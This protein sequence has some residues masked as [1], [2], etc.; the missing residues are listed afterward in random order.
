MQII[1]QLTNTNG[2]PTIYLPLFVIVFISMVKDLFEDL[3]RH[4]SDKEENMKEVLLLENETFVR[5]EWQEL[6]CGN[7]I[8]VF[9][10]FKDY[11]IIF[12]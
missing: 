9:I 1:P 8:K 11:M 10:L 5:A 7:I 3:K 2:S 4:N 6:R 12:V